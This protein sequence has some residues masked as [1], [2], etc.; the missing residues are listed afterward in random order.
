MTSES[1][2]THRTFSTE[3]PLYRLDGSNGQA[4]ILLQVDALI[5]VKYRTK[6]GDDDVSMGNNI[7]KTIEKRIASSMLFFF[8]FFQEA[9]IYVP[10]YA[11]VTG[12]CDNQNT[13]T[14]SLKWDAYVLSWSFA[15]VDN[16]RFLLVRQLE[17]KSVTSSKRLITSD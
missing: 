17:Q 4:C 10:T 2:T 11:T 12:N 9:N 16:I 7:R 5:T 3:Q 1:T 13:V 15:K 6:T 14:M 8:F